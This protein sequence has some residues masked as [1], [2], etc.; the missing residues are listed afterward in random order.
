LSYVNH[1][2]LNFAE[3]LGEVF[4]DI[5]VE[6]L[7]AMIKPVAFAKRN[8]MDRQPLVEGIP[9]PISLKYIIWFG[10]LV[11]NDEDFMAMLNCFTGQTPGI[12]LGSGVKFR[13]EGVNGQ[14]D[15]HLLTPTGLR[16]Y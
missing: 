9:D 1:V 2:R 16:G 7:L 14:D 15:T 3:I 10:R 5:L 12:H 6:K 13:E 4:F 8:A 11:T